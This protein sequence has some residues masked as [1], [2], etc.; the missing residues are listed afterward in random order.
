VLSKSEITVLDEVCK[1]LGHLSAWQLEEL[2]HKEPA[3]I[4]AD[5]NKPMNFLHFFEGHPEAS[6][7]RDILVEEQEGVM[8]LSAS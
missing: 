6:L 3:W 7:I 4:H 2:S 8:A 1:K 5:R